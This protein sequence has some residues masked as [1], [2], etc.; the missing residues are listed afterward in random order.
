MEWI[1]GGGFMLV[2]LLTLATFLLSVAATVEVARSRLLVGRLDRYG[3]VEMDRYPRISVIAAAHNEARSIESAV[4]SWLAQDYPNLEIVL[5]DDRSQDLTGTIV[6]KLAQHDQRIR[7]VHIDQLPSG[8]M[9]KH[10]ALWR[11]WHVATGDWLLFTDADVHMEPSVLRRAIHYA[12]REGLDHLT[13]APELVAPGPLLAAWV[14]VF[15]FLFVAFQRPH[16]ARRQRAKDSAGI[17]AFNLIRRTAYEAIGTHRAI[18]LRPDDDAQL[19]KRVKTRG[20]RQDVMVAGPLIRV[21]W[22]WHIKDAMAGLEKN[23]LASFDYRWGLAALAVSVI[24]VLVLL[25]WPILVAADG[26]VRF[27]GAGAAFAQLVGYVLANPKPLWRGLVVY[28]LAAVFVVYS[29]V[30]AVVRPVVRGGFE[31]GGR[32]FR[33][34]DLKRCSG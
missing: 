29:L 1:P 16:R 34:S 21:V 18:A 25:P 6:D 3:P 17:G 12:Q 28:P 33:L 11:G 7:A 23:T 15:T 2:P 31:W 26:L 22:Y 24:A 20:L 8:W 19:G 27:L 14:G 9:G 30:R 32:F 4:R 13:V 10:H 5:V